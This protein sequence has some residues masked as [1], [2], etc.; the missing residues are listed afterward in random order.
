MGV[1]LAARKAEVEARI[2]AL[3]G[4]VFNIGSTKQ[5]GDVLFEELKLPI[6]KRT[7]TPTQ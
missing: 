7:K 2:H 5:L 3:A 1:E 4:R 6:T